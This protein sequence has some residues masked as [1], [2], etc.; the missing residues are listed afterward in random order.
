MVYETSSQTNSKF[1]IAITDTYDFLGIFVSLR[2]EY[3]F[4]SPLQ[5]D[6]ARLSSPLCPL[7]VASNPRVSQENKTMLWLLHFL[8]LQ[9]TDLESRLS[10]QTWRHHSRRSRDIVAIPADHLQYLFLLSLSSF[11]SFPRGN[12]ERR[13]QSNTD[14]RMGPEIDCN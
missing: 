12:Y 11:L 9:F 2:Q 8:F 10:P 14:I 6:Y 3:F 7:G 4:Q 13:A 5:E 1:N